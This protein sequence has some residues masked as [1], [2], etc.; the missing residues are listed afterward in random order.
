MQ[1]GIYT[2][3]ANSSGQMLFPIDVQ[4]ARDWQHVKLC[5]ESDGDLYSIVPCT[6]GSAQFK[7]NTASFVT[8]SSTSGS[9]SFSSSSSSSSM[10]FNDNDRDSNNELYDAASDNDSENNEEETSLNLSPDACDDVVSTV[11]NINADGFYVDEVEDELICFTGGNDI[12][13]EIAHRFLYL[14]HLLTIKCV[15]ILLLFNMSNCCCCC[16]WWWCCCCCCCC[17]CCYCCCCCCFC[18]CCYGFLVILVVLFIMYYLFVVVVVVVVVVV[19]FC[20]CYCCF[21]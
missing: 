20:C 19:I 10:E 5:V 9:C 8:T 4:T 2:W 18:C 15:I 21:Y 14:T 11:K 3:A 16:C 1:Y 13:K 6:D 7:E 17:C 12:V